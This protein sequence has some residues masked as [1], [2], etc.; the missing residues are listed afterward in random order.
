MEPLGV[1]SFD[2]G[3]RNYYSFSLVTRRP[4]EE[5]WG[6]LTGTRPL[7]WCRGLR[8]V[9]WTSAGGAA[10]TG[11][12]IDRGIGRGVGA[13]RSVVSGNRARLE[14][15]YFQWDVDEA[16]RYVNA[17]SVETASVPLFRRFGERYTVTKSQPWT[18]LS[19]EFVIEPNGVGPL[20]CAARRLV[21]HDIEKIRL[22]TIAHFG[23]Q[24]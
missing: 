13:T 5:V 18:R 4:I 14:E 15:R 20:L 17:F 11:S 7:R 8:S 2:P 10:G 12:D 1:D 16:S 6:D 24:R 22:D 9:T 19:W 23:S 3:D 21:A